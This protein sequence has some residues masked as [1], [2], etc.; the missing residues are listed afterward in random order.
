MGNMLNGKRSILNNDSETK[1][2]VASSVLAS[3]MRTYVA[4]DT[5]AT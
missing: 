4:K 3:S 2:F 1:A 5:R